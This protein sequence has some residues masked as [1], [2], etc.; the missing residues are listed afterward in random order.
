MGEG[1]SQAFC[2]S[3]QMLVTAHLVTK[4]LAWCDESIKLHTNPTSTTHLRAYVAGRNAHHLGT[5]S[6]TLEGEEVSQS[7]PS[8][9]HPDGRTPHQFHMDVGDLGDAQLWQLMEDIWQ[10]V[11]HRELS[12]FPGATLGPCEDSCRRRGS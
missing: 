6:L 1:H 9:T 10:E 2:S 3:E 4:A 8:D 11:A 12:A 7:P 5:Q